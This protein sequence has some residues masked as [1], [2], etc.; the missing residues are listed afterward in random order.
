MSTD[1]NSPSNDSISIE[2]LKVQ[3]FLD[4][5]MANKETNEIEFK[6]AKG[7][8]PGSFWETYSS[9][10]NTNGGIIVFGVKEHA[11]IFSVEGLSEDAVA[12]YRQHFFNLQNNKQNINQ[13]LLT[14]KDVA[15]IPYEDKLIL[16]FV[17][18][19][20]TREQRPVYRG[21][22]PYSGTYRR[23][24]EGD[25]LCPASSVTQMFAD[26][27]TSATQE[28]RI[29]AGYT[30]DDIDQTSLRQYRNIFANLTP[31]H[32]WAALDDLELLKKLGAYRKDRATGKEGFTVA[33]MLMFGKYESI[34][35]PE[36][37]PDFMVD[38]RDIPADT[39][40]ARWID[41]VYPNGTWEANLFQFY[42]IVLPKLQAFLPK[43]F[44]IENDTRIDETPAHEALREAFVNCCVHA[45]YGAN[46]RIV[47]KKF[48]DLL[49]F[50]N[51]GTLLVSLQQYYEGGYSE[52]RNPAL[53]KMFGLIGRSDKAGSGADKI[54]KGWST[55]NWRR[56][57][58]NET[59]MPDR[60]ELFLPM[61]TL[62][63]DAAPNSG[64]SSR[65]DSCDS[66]KLN[67]NELK[68]GDTNIGGDT[69]GDT[70]NESSLGSTTDYKRF[71]KIA[72]QACRQWQSSGEIA[73][74]IGLS[75][76][77]TRQFV[78]KRLVQ[79]GLLTLKYP[80]KPNHPAQR[81]RA[82]KRT[83]KLR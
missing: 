17:I 4:E 55:T 76:N 32:P 79:Q 21:T 28:S 37:L 9:F 73:T 68:Q 58:L 42:R 59:A 63:A 44:I 7:G 25:Y 13:P 81:Y 36:C 69:P 60:V 54:M 14:D 75:L 23:N 20:A 33:G 82:V 57:Y 48:N 74:A 70:S 19:R 53:Q 26:K 47:I 43:P 49:V 12:G 46:A 35:D 3:S 65:G 11:G 34:T 80:D 5:L 15:T 72:L 1:T 30:F 41:R 50:S 66:N 51:P 67:S 2:S 8:F 83:A 62:V 6:S 40:T 78:I 16:A 31:T 61:S 18:P 10:A 56:P 24:N 77:R 39:S 27:S 45:A 38:Y 29:L 52:C 64:D 22:D 71:D